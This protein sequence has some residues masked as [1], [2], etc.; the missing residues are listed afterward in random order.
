MYTPVYTLHP[1]RRG[2]HFCSMRFC[3]CML[4]WNA[5]EIQYMCSY[6]ITFTRSVTLPLFIF[7]QSATGLVSFFSHSACNDCIC[8]TPVEWSKIIILSFRFKAFSH[9]HQF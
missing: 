3:M 8:H 7:S 5:T 6:L 9:F 2:S 1:L 4:Y